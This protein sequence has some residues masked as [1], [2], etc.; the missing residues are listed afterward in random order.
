MIDE[1]NSGRGLF[2]FRRSA[3][4][5]IAGDRELMLRQA[6][7]RAR[8]AEERARRLEEQLQNGKGGGSKNGASPGRRDRVG[9][10]IARRAAASPGLA[11]LPPE[12]LE[13][14]VGAIVTAAEEAAGQLARTNGA[15]DLDPDLLRRE[16]SVAASTARTADPA[17]REA[18]EQ[19]ADV[20]R[21]VRELPDRLVD[22]LKPLAEAVREAD[23][24]LAGLRDPGEPGDPG[25]AQEPDATR[26]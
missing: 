26:P 12:Q 24:R 3:L 10:S 18:R 20:R 15:V 4:D 19:L 14:L 5:R 7:Q 2:R 11:S 21:A 17:V 22:A 13:A 8:D 23:A 16:M 25:S 6:E 1:P 9:E